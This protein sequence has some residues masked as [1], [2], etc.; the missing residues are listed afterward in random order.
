MKKFEFTLGRMLDYKDQLL[1]K[2]KNGLMQLR[3]Q[4]EKIDNK[5]QSLQ[6][7]FSTLNDSLVEKSKKGIS[8]NEIQCF[9]FQMENIRKQIKQLKLEQA[10]MASAVERQLQVVIALS[11]EVTGLDKLQEKQLEEYKYLQ[12][13]ADEL[14]IS[15]YIT[16]TIFKQKQA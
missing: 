16:G 14:V 9:N 3:K 6:N 13:K 12:N 4:K 1:D 10:A 11:Q 5:I 2:E 8:V 15:E 7:D